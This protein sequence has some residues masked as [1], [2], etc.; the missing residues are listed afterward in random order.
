MVEAREAEAK[1]GVSL[2]AGGL[3]F[4]SLLEEFI[5]FLPLVICAR[6]FIFHIG[7]GSS[8]HLVCIVMK[9]YRIGAT[10][11]VYLCAVSEYICAEILELSGNAVKGSSRCSSRHT[12]PYRFININVDL[13]VKRVSPRHILLAVRGD[14]ELDSLFK[15][16]DSSFSIYTPLLA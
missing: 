4:S 7:N 3:V 9:G 11:A 13:H 10:A 2:E 8:D 14:E 12:L 1:Q 16:P 6:T 5:A 15:G